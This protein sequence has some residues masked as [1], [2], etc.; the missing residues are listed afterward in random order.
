MTTH[1]AGSHGD[2]GLPV[3]V[4]PHGRYSIGALGIINSED[5]DQTVMMPKWCRRE[6]RAES[7]S[8]RKRGFSRKH[9]DFALSKITGLLNKQSRSLGSVWFDSVHE[10][11]R[12]EV[13]LSVANAHFEQR[14]IARTAGNLRLH[15]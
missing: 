13:I 2:G 11:H 1:L 9:Q 15:R 14:F 12:S 7:H 8:P 6:R 4:E 5:S 3:W 10:D